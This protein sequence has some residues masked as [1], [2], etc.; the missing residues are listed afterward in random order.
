MFSKEWIEKNIYKVIIGALLTA[1]LAALTTAS[2]IIYGYESHVTG[3][4]S[5]HQV[6]LV[7]VKTNEDRIYKLPGRLLDEQR[8][9]EFF[10]ERE[11]EGTKRDTASMNTYNIKSQ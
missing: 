8:A 3:N 5:T 2:V 6:I 7:L 9:R 10:K 11:K 1:N 4:D